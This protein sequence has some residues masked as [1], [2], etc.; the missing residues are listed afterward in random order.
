MATLSPRGLIILVILFFL[1]FGPDSQTTTPTQPTGSEESI[2]EERAALDVLNRTQYGDFDVQEGRW[3]EKLA[4]LREEDGYGWSPLEDV[5]TR[6]K[7]QAVHILG[8]HAAGLLG[9]SSDDTLPLYHN[10]SGYLRGEWVRSKVAP[11][12]DSPV[13]HSTT[14]SSRNIGGAGGNVRIEFEEKDRYKKIESSG[15]AV[16]FIKAGLTIQDDS[17]WGDGWN[18]ILYGVH[19]LRSGSIL[20]TTT[21]EK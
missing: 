19:F 7:E 8:D 13:Q 5:K 1:L 9:G 11:H 14:E 18:I 3:L 20:L 21:S 4:G 6:V 10:V 15:G 17:S 16:G 2:A 12:M